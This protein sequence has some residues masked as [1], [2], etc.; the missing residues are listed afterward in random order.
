LLYQRRKRRL[1]NLRHDQKTKSRNE[2]TQRF[3]GVT[4]RGRGN[5]L[6]QAQGCR[7]DWI[8]VRSVSVFILKHKGLNYCRIF[9]GDETLSL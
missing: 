5:G 2:I 9:C 1:L 7:E 6:E 3:L 8:R 4:R